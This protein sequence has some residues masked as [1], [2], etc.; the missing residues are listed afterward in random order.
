MTP[1]GVE[2]PAQPPAQPPAPTPNFADSAAGAGVG[3]V[4]GLSTPNL[5]G[6]AFGG[7]SN[8]MMAP[9]QVMPGALNGQTFVVGVTNL[10]PTTTTQTIF[11]PPS[12]SS[13]GNG[14]FMTVTTVN[15]NQ[16]NGNFSN[17]S[18]SL[19]NGSATTLLP[20]APIVV[21]GIPISNPTQLQALGIHGSFTQ[22]I[23]GTNMVFTPSGAGAANATYI[24]Q[25]AGGTSAVAPAGTTITIPA[26][27][28]FG[29]ARNTLALAAEQQVH[30]GARI[31]TFAL[32]PVQAV[33]DGSEL[34]Y[35]STI[36]DTI[37]TPG[38]LK[39]VMLAVSIPGGFGG[40]AGGPGGGGV[41]GIVKISE[42]NSPMPRDRVIFD[43]DYFSNVP[44]TPNGIPVNR[45][46]FG[47]EKTFFDGWTS[48]E[49]R[50]PFASTLNSDGTLGTT[51]TNTEFGNVRLALKALLLRRPKVNIS[52]GMAMYLPTA[53]DIHIRQDNGADL[54]HINNSSVQ[55]A[56]Y[57]AIL[58]TPNDRFFSQ[59]WL[60]ATIDTA[61]NRVTVD[62]TV[63]GGPSNI[64]NVRAATILSADLQVGYWVY[65][66]DYG[67]LRG[68]APFVEMHYN[69]AV[70][71]GAALNAGNGFF[72]G[73]VNN[74]FNE[75]IMTSG[76]TARLA[77]NGLLSIGAGAPLR[78]APDR[79]FDYQVGVRFSY[80]F[81]YTA[82]NQ[83]PATRVSTFQ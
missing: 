51:G 37:S 6:D 54:I 42:D 63:F 7:G 31:E 45:Y 68:L 65:R 44:L 19:R 39:P 33:Y 10:S 29:A 77:Q 56:P 57:G 21:N 81:G 35:Y 69:G 41:V 50:A 48:V 55:L 53:S 26:A 40:G 24:L 38:T 36:T 3:S 30:P 52:T 47:L 14:S 64:G 28:P 74:N 59:A 17:G 34:R 67:V 2:P 70:T 75:W 16:L 83:S 58:W 4:V 80:F 62:P 11:I 78:N 46:Q 22:T 43:Y 66:S 25:Y 73:D 23:P 76:V 8:Q 12:G 72:I 18:L 32:G 60:A 61:G 79:R 1:P 71:N 9:R 5:F 15:N 49:F 82:R 27:V 20:I 13:G